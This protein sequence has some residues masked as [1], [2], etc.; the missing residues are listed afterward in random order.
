MHENNCKMKA[1]CLKY[2]KKTENVDPEISSTR[3]DTT[4]ISKC[5]ICGGKKSR[6]NKTQEAK[7]L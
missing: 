1:Y 6:F 3:N 2:K 5:A 7:G 4:M